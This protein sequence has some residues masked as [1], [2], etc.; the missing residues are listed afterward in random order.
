MDDCCEVRCEVSLTV[1][2]CNT[3]ILMNASGNYRFPD[4]IDMRQ[5]IRK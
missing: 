5:E 4:G 2:T 3:K 1:N